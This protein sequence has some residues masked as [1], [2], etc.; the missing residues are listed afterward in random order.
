[1]H[2]GSSGRGGSEHGG[3]FPMPESHLAVLREVRYNGPM[4]PISFL[5]TYGRDLL[6]II[7][8]ISGLVFTALSFRQ[9]ARTRKV[10]TLLNLTSEHRSIWKELYS[11]PEI[12]R[13]IDPTLPKN[14]EPT[15]GEA[16][17]INSIIQQA[18]CV[19]RAGQLGALMS[20][21]GIAK[22]IGQFF[23]LPLPSKIWADARNFHDLDFVTFI[24]E[25]IAECR[26]SVAGNSTDVRSFSF[27][28][29]GLAAITRDA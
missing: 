6:E 29:S 15:Q 26:D 22:D 23:A 28:D 24:E 17:F 8:V 18:H 20:L 9:D 5:V 2:W 25:G 12:Q 7:G 11:K 3:I 21:K 27:E 16:V 4:H 1:M 13:V 10:G 14:A 19:F